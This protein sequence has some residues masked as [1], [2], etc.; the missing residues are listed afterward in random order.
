MLAPI[1]RVTKELNLEAHQLREWEKRD[2]LGDVLKDPDNN[3]QRVYTQEQV[4]RIEFIRDAIAE[5]R[6]KGFKRTDLQQIEAKL[7]DR[8]GGEIKKID[9]EIMVHP[10]SME[11]I[12]EL[13]QLQ[14]KKIMELQEIIIQ[15]QQRELPEPVDHSETL[16]Q[17]QN[18]LK[19]SAEREEKLLSLVEKLQD[20]VEKLKEMPPKS[21]WK[22]WR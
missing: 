7:L 16:S 22:F 18:E 2:W 6:E 15:Q 8:F 20:D 4:E 9:T 3:N 21:R 17:V 11:Q 19:F 14:N 12:V 13:I 1:S 5:Q 10:N